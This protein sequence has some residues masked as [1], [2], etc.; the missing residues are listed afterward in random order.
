M[1]GIA[2]LPLHGGHVPPWMLKIMTKL[3]E[4]IVKYMVNEKG[5]KAVISMLSD[6]IWF[7]AFNN[8]IGMDWDSSGSTT[9]VLGILKSITWKDPSLGIL[10]LGGKGS[11]MKLV[12]EEANEA[13]RVFDLD[14]LE[15]VKFSKL[16]A[17]ADSAFLQDGYD[18]YHHAVIISE[19]S[20]LL[21][22]QQG[23][24]T[25]EGYARRYHINKLELLEP[26]SGIA[27]IPRENVLLNLTKKESEKTL[28]TFIEIISSEGA[29]L[30][31]RLEQ[32]VAIL[33]KKRTLLDYIQKST[34]EYQSTVSP[35]IVPYYKPV[36]IT[37][38]L[39]KNLEKLG[40]MSLIDPKE[41]GLSPGV[42]PRVVRALALIADLIYG[43]PSSTEDSVTHPLNPFTYAYAVGGKDG[44]PYRFD[45]RTAIFAYRYLMSALEESKL[46][47]ETKSK[48]LRRLSRKL[49][50]YLENTQ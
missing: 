27:G 46:D 41:L 19:D 10:V 36:K 23:M 37:P 3:S 21:V 34:S 6:P 29:R 47:R 11:R 26:H 22:I 16:A 12:P 48:A 43:V 18:L 44:I 39:K 38:Q 30:P 7:Q 50:K 14:P 17:R 31:H 49:R 4:A 5:P 40:S 20:S 9:V 42:G 25:D 35:K 33:K 28:H 24:N 8:V 32:A 1:P 45:P 15:I 2:D 13:S